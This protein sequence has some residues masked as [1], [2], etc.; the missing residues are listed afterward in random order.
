MAS[1]TVSRARAFE[2][3]VKIE[4]S[5][6]AFKAEDHFV[7]WVKKPDL[8]EWKYVTA[9]V[10]APTQGK[11]VVLIAWYALG[12]NGPALYGSSSFFDEKGWNSGAEVAFS[13]GVPVKFRTA[14]I[15]DNPKKKSEIAKL[16]FDDHEAAGEYVGWVVYVIAGEKRV[17]AYKGS[18][19]KMEEQW[20]KDCPTFLKPNGEKFDPNYVPPKNPFDEPS[21][22]DP[23]PAPGF[24][25]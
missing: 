8:Y 15:F 20:V 6:S 1:A 4:T 3:L 11:G 23:I 21:K 24:D 13:A 7:D 17:L 10:T 14:H 5:E 16:G 22:G 12:P 19:V 2:N 18:S 25:D 9:S